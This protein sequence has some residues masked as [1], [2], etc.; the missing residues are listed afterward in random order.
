MKFIDADFDTSV[1]WS[2]FNKKTGLILKTN[3]KPWVL[4][5]RRDARANARLYPSYEVD[6]ILVDIERT[7]NNA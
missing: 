5:S 4:R 3:G 6:K 7:H 1:M 2:L